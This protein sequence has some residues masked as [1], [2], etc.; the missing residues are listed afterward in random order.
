MLLAIPVL[1]GLGGATEP[2]GSAS[3][4]HRSGGVLSG[5]VGTRVEPGSNELWAFAQTYAD[6]KG[7]RF[8]PGASDW[9]RQ[10]TVDGLREIETSAPAARKKK[11]DEG[12]ENIAR[13]IDAMIRAS[14]E[15]P[16]Y[17]GRHPYVI[18][19]ETYMKAQG[20]LCP[21]WPICRRR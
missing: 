15:I 11:V 21:I 19:E 18:G 14:R 3:S 5:D 9:L 8:G 1:S 12:K 2:I 6:S 16:G 10:A 20:W 4:E 13:F 17:S 7:Y